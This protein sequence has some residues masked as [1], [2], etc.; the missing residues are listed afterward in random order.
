MASSLSG[1]VALVTG[2]TTGLGKEIALTLGRAGAK[3]GVNYFRNEK[4]AEQA[5]QEFENEGIESVLVRSDVTTPEGANELCSTVASKLG[6]IDILVVN[7]TPD[8]PQMPIEEYTWKHYEDMLDFFIKSPYLLT[9]AVLPKMKE[10]K[11]GRIINL[12]SEVFNN[13][14]GDFSAYVSAKGGQTGFTRSMATELTPHGITVNMVAPGWIPT[15]RHE[16]DPQEAKDGYFATIP[17]GRWG[18]PADVAH[19]VL[20]FASEQAGFVT[21]QYLCVNGGRSVWF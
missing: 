17:M 1:H 14:V 16:N 3:I 10:K 15:E 18:V 9:R 19:A 8:Q 11:W 12:G 4:R 21:G 5:S 13:G 20:Y 2:S 7:A 6:E